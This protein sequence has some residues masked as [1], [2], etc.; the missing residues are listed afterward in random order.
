MGN[1][2]K[3]IVGI[4][5]FT[6][7]LL[8]F[9]EGFKIDY[10]YFVQ[11]THFPPPQYDFSKNQQTEVGFTLGKKLFYDPILSRDSTTSCASCHLQF[12]G[13]THVD[14]D[15]SHGI[16]G[17]KGTRNAS[18]LINL[19]WNTSF[20]WDGGVNNLEVQAINPIT[21]PAEM[22]NSLENALKSLNQSAVY[23]KYFFNAFGD[24][25]ATSQKLLKAL[26]QFTVSF[27]SYNSKY[28]KYMRQ[29]SG[30][31]MTEQELNGLKLFR[32]YC[33]ACHKE[34]LFTDFSFQNNGLPIESFYKDLGR[35][36]ITQNPA[37]SLKFKVPTLRNIEF[38][39]PYM[40]DGRFKKLKEVI[41]HYTTLNTEGG[42]QPA[43]SALKSFQ[44]PIILNPNEKKDVIAFLLT[45]TDKEFLYNPNFGFPRD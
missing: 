16:D 36:R 38:S 28:D 32:T 7:F 35:Y 12:T 19:A 23:R 39:Y 34:P 33:A 4:V 43:Q 8:S 41:N 25:V 29:E 24:S 21:H 37:D 15:V 44:K 2:P 11:P 9:T 26:A 31:E 22:D 27:V 30:G 3:W 42:L 14:H 5:F 40:H 20:H 10:P 45:L 13:F 1:K 18:A 6:A 17:R